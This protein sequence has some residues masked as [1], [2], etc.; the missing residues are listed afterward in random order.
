MP[1]LARVSR[2]LAD[3]L[4]APQRSISGQRRTSC[5][6][7]DRRG[8]RQDGEQ[9]TLHPRLELGDGGSEQHGQGR[10]DEFRHGITDAS[11]AVS[12]A[13]PATRRPSA[14]RPGARRRSPPTTRRHAAADVQRPWNEAATFARNHQR[15]I[16][17]GPTGADRDALAAE[18]LRVHKLA[19]VPPGSIV[20][21]RS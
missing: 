9:L 6:D 4:P 17:C 10:V 3:A 1:D 12:A 15:R 7:R 11:A 16:V 21:P 18:Y 19:G 14:R 8:A 2:P 20:R 13:P 5:H